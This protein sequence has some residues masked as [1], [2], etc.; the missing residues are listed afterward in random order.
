[1]VIHKKCTGLKQ[2]EFLFNK[3]SKDTVWECIDCQ[4]KKLPFVTLTNHKIQNIFQ[5]NSIV[6]AKQQ[7]LI[8]MTLLTL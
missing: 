4:S 5:L 6:N 3:V 7:F 1:M 8:L 2:F